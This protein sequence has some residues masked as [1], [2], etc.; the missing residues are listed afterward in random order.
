MIYLLLLIALGAFLFSSFFRSQEDTPIIPLDQVVAGIN[1]DK[2]ERITVRGDELYI[3]RTDGSAVLSRKEPNATVLETLLHL[4]VS[5]EALG[6]V[7]IEFALPS[8][9]E[10]WGPILATF[11]PLVFVAVFFIFLL[12][13]AQGAGN[14]AL[15]FG[16]SRARMF[17]GDRP[18]VTFED[19][20]G[21]EEAKEGLQEVVEFLKEPQKFAALGAR[22]PKGVILVGAPGTGKTLMA[23]AVSG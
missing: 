19:V 3:E 23:K 9:W 11:L 21:V 2:V 16:R 14:Q 22:I 1:S 10:S 6:G 7:E 12:R 13:Q 20:A 17:T 4:G 5:Q 15:S 8:R 18:T